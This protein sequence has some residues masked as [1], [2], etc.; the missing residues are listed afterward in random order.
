MAN[1]TKKASNT[2]T[3]SIGARQERHPADARVRGKRDVN[4]VSDK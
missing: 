2:W 3:L 1:P 4:K